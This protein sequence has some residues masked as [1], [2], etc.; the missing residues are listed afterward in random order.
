M[1]VCV[2]NQHWLFP[3]AC[4]TDG[5]GFLVLLVLVHLPL[6][7]TTNKSSYFYK[8]C[9]FWLQRYLPILPDYMSLLSIWLFKICNRPAETVKIKGGRVIVIYPAVRSVLRSYSGRNDAVSRSPFIFCSWF[10]GLRIWLFYILLPF[11]SVI[12][13]R[14]YR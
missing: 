13:I 1:F 6:N 12:R 5:Q 4:L 7:A 8:S 10:F 2:W 9:H 3:S 11:I 14:K